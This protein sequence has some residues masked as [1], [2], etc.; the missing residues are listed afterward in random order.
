MVMRLV[1]RFAVLEKVVVGITV[2]RLEGL[3]ILLTVVLHAV[4]LI[5]SL[6]S[7]TS[8]DANSNSSSTILEH[9]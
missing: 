4:T 3:Y 6:S 5:A 2:C 1:I 9:I 7:L 8:R